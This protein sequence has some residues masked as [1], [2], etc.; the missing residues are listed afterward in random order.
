[1]DEPMVTLPLSAARALFGVYDTWMNKVDCYDPDGMPGIGSLL[2]TKGAFAMEEATDAVEPHEA[3][4]R[5][6]LA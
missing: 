6:A 1:M 5:E 2:G 4:I 3:A